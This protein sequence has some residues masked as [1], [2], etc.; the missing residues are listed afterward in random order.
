MEH[1]IQVG[2]CYVIRANPTKI[3]VLG[4]IKFKD[5]QALGLMKYNI[6]NNPHIYKKVSK[7]WKELIGQKL[8]IMGNTP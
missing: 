3:Y 1:K 4:D 8:K 6:N 7:I 2:D 5:S